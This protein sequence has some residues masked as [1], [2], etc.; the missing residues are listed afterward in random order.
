MNAKQIRR[1]NST[2]ETAV[3]KA[4]TL[5]MNVESFDDE[6]QSEIYIDTETGQVSASELMPSDVEDCDSYSLLEENNKDNYKSL[7]Y[8]KSW[9]VTDYFELEQDYDEKTCIE[10]SIEEKEKDIGDEINSNIEEDFYEEGIPL[11][12]G[13]DTLFQIQMKERQ[14][15][16]IKDRWVKQ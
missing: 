9:L 14:Y 11:K 16:F 10:F 13:C 4:V 15:K 8:V 6:E 2:L 5:T 3:N 12:N 1:Y 7:C